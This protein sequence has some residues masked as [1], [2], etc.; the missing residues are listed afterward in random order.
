MTVGRLHEPFHHPRSQGFL[1]RV[2]GVYD[3]ADASE[4][5][6]ARSDRD[7]E[8]LYHT[9]GAVR[10]P[11][12]YGGESDSHRLP[13][14]LS[15]WEDL[16]SVAAYA[17]SGPHGEALSHRRE[18]FSET[19]L[20]EYVA[21]WVDPAADRVDWQEAADRLDYLHEHGPTAHAFNFKQPF[22]PDGNPVTLDRAKI[23]ARST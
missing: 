13:S 15:L 3:A 18:W 8:T 12:C 5:F 14:T 7:L 23:K 22:D 21:F 20:P 4:G 11:R 19:D 6:I 1:D 2:P 16:E 9:W 17:Y 10:H